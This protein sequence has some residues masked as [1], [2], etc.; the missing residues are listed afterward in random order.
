M[1]VKNII[2]ILIVSIFLYITLNFIYVNSSN[3]AIEVIEVNAGHTKVNVNNAFQYCYDMRYPTSSLGNNSLD[4]HMATAKDWGGVA[5]LALSSYGAVKSGSGP[6]Y[7]GI[8]YNFYTSTGNKTGVINLGYNHYGGRCVE[9]ACYL[10]GSTE[11]GNRSKLYLE[12][13][14]RLV[15]VISA[16]NNAENTRGMALAETRG[17]YSSAAYYLNDTNNPIMIRE[18]I[19]GY[20]NRQQGGANIAGDGAGNQIHARTDF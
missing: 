3:A 5:Y 18:G 9:L 17:W 8:G 16:T 6:S 12:S 4:P 19:L 20:W 1:K 14:R 7:S 2:K 10:E 11:N 15:N 13:N